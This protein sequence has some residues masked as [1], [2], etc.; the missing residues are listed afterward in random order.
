MSAEIPSSQEPKSQTPVDKI[1][2]QYEK[3]RANEGVLPALGELRVSLRS[4]HEVPYL[5]R[6]YILKEKADKELV[7]TNEDDPTNTDLKSELTNLLEACSEIERT[8]LKEQTE[9]DSEKKL[10][11]QAMETDE[12][13]FGLR[14]PKR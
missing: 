9:K 5:R 6:I 12:K 3:T 4:L 10:M 11:R 2:A 14:R 8:H 7:I 13:R 1:F